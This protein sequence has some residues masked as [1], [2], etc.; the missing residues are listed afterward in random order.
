MQ[1]LS[2]KTPGHRQVS[3][4][5]VKATKAGQGW[6]EI[7]V[8]G[9]IAKTSNKASY[10]L[11]CTT[12]SSGLALS[13]SVRPKAQTV[14]SCA[15]AAPSLTAVGSIKAKKAESVSYYWALAD[16][17]NSAT[18]TVKFKAAGT[19]TLPPLTITPPALPASGEVVLVVT[20]PVAAASKPA[21]YTVSCVAPVV[22]TVPVQPGST[23]PALKREFREIVAEPGQGD[24]EADAHCL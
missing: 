5:S 20:K 19:K 3:G 6:A 1:T 18:R 15:A 21:T 10:R 24:C 7:K 17:Q 11:L 23:S 13:A 14:Y 8:L 12:A 2:F 22:A 9:A 16:G 4:G